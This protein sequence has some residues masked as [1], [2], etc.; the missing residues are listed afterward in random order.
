[1]PAQSCL[2]LEMS[3]KHKRLLISKL[4]AECQGA[5]GLKAAEIGI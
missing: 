2:L 5:I 3:M 1:M 4:A